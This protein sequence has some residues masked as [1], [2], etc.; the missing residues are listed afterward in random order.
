MSPETVQALR[1]M[2]GLLDD[3]ILTEAEFSAQ[4]GELLERE[5]I[6]ALMELKVLTP[7]KALKQLGLKKSDEVV[8]PVLENY[9]K[10]RGAI[11]CFQFLSAGACWGI[12]S[13]VYMFLLIEV[14]GMTSGEAALWS[15][16]EWMTFS[17]GQLITVPI[18]GALTDR[19]GRRNPMLFG[20]TILSVGCA[21]Y[22]WPNGPWW[23]FVGLVQGLCDC[24]WAT[25]NAIIVDCVA[26]GAPPG[27]ESDYAYVQYLKSLFMNGQK[28][29]EIEE[30]ETP[31]TERKKSS[32][33]D[34]DHGLTITWLHALIGRL[35]GFGLG[36]FLVD[37][38]GYVFTMMMT[39]IITLPSIAIFYYVLP[40]ET[41][42]DETKPLAEEISDSKITTSHDDDHN[43]VLKDDEEEK[44]SAVEFMEE[45]TPKKKE[46]SWADMKVAI[47]GEVLESIKAQ[48]QALSLVFGDYRSGLLACA[49]LF[50]SFTRAGTLNFGVFW[51][52]VIYAWTPAEATIFFVNVTLAPIFGAFLVTGKLAPKLGYTRALTSIILLSAAVCAALAAGAFSPVLVFFAVVLA[53]LAFGTYASILA[54]LTEK[55]AHANVGHLQGCLFAFIQLGTL[56]ALGLYLVAFAADPA[57]LWILN[58]LAFLLCALLI[59]LA[60]DGLLPKHIPA[61]IAA[62]VAGGTATTAKTADYTLQVAATDFQDDDDE[63]SPK[64][65]ALV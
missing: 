53:V 37:F 55:V 2:K 32:R 26:K 5:K 64:G 60:G 6:K 29:E 22:A 40:N 25:A 27:D 52:E 11:Y 4:K 61:V 9:R 45:I 65:T 51:G 47:Y 17:I 1:D 38:T 62:A 7:A 44:E 41:F 46:E 3:G 28:E 58:T 24:T 36:L 39:G 20:S 63:T 31:R 54:L 59:C 48:S 13:V 49:Y 34:L 15:T 23:A 33:R 10:S 16:V 19:I 8:D 56:S 57:W 42:L 43:K 30:P 18:W 21:A 12:F 35:F 14:G 50:I